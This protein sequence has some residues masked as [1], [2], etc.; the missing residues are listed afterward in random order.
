MIFAQP[1]T[2]APT[3]TADAYAAEKEL[4]R[5]AV[6]AHGGEKL[7]GMK[8]LV[9]GG[10]VDVTAS[11]FPQPIP[12]TFVMIFSGDRYRVEI[13]NPF[14]PLRQA[15]DGTQTITSIS[16]GFTLPPFNRVGFPVLQHVGDPGFAVTS[17]PDNKKKKKGFRVTT[18]EGYITDFYL[19]EKTN[20]VKSF[21]S[22]YEVNGRSVKTSAEIDKLKVVDGVTVPEKYVQRFD[23]DQLT[24]FA[25]FLAKQIQVNTEV[26]ND[27][28]TKVN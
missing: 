9:L 26:A 22:I 4:A 8:T 17:V 24:F 27:V 20:Q 10:S 15:Y 12:A 25:A 19:D 6:A 21:D 13:N 28:F 18:P 3:T 7:R 2:V 11:T 23:L 5:L 14:Q 16:N 1:K